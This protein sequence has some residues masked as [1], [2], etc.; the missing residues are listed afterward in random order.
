MSLGRLQGVVFTAVVVGVCGLQGAERIREAG[1]RE[2]LLAE[3]RAALEERGAAQGVALADLPNPFLFVQP[4]AI[5]VEPEPE[6]EGPKE[7]VVSNEEVLG[8]AISTLEPRGVMTFGGQQILT[9]DIGPQRSQLKRAGETFSY[10][11]E[12]RYYTI[13]F[14]EVTRNGFTIQLGDVQREIPLTEQQGRI[15]RD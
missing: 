3:A 14:I 11:Y 10:F 12:G 8:A 13:T 9:V 4:E 15:E 5:E 6:P 7:K 1:Q 2:A